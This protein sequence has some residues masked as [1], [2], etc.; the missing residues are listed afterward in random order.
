M[1]CLRGRAFENFDSTFAPNCSCME[2]IPLDNALG[3]AFKKFF[4]AKKE[5]EAATKLFEVVL[6]LMGVC[7]KINGL[8]ANMGGDPKKLG[9]PVDPGDKV[10]KELD[11][12]G[13]GEEEAWYGEKESRCETSFLIS[14]EEF[15]REEKSEA[16]LDNG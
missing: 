7:E 12:D 8:I 10:P 4:C 6:K 5:A 9:L 16:L 13:V 15:L 1:Y 2:P 14:L 3:K 11:V